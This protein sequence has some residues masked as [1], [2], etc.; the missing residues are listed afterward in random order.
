MKSLRTLLFTI[1]VESVIATLFEL[2]VHPSI[3][4]LAV[5]LVGPEQL[6]CYSQKELS[7]SGP[8]C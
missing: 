8:S 2:S 4:S 3:E 6:S 1:L 7:C 5:L